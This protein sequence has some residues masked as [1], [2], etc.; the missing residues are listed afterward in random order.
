MA[1]RDCVL[2]SDSSNCSGYLCMHAVSFCAECLLRGVHFVIPMSSVRLR[3]EAG[4]LLQDPLPVHF[5]DLPGC[6]R[7]TGRQQEGL[8]R[9]NMD[10]WWCVMDKLYFESWMP[11]KGSTLCNVNKWPVEGNITHLIWKRQCSCSRH[12]TFENVFSTEIIAFSSVPGGRPRWQNSHCPWW[13][14]GLHAPCR[15]HGGAPP[16]CYTNWNHWVVGLTVCYCWSGSSQAPPLAHLR[17]PL[18]SSPSP[19][20]GCYCLQWQSGCQRHKVSKKWEW[21]RCL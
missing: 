15:K 13:R 5:D 7:L 19:S 4:L 14:A 20:P 9:E 8:G 11:L 12:Y 21:A 6:R 2:H 16:R 17:P 3:H 1:G 18:M 10:I